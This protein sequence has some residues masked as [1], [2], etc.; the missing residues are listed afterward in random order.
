MTPDEKAALERLIE[1]SKS[2]TGQSRRVADF[3]LA[4]WNAGDCGGWDPTDLWGVDAAIA[5]D[6]MTA[7]RARIANIP[8]SRLPELLPWNWSPARNARQEAA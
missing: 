3:L 4:W 8:V 1:I 2:E 7:I 5:D 6:M